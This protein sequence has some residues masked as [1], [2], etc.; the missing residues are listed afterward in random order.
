MKIS[1]GKLKFQKLATLVRN[2]H[3]NAAVPGPLV[4][5]RTLHKIGT[6]SQARLS[7]KFYHYSG[8]ILSTSWVFFGA[9]SQNTQNYHQLGS[10]TATLPNLDL[11]AAT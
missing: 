11:V 4:R 2:S 10:A 3:R 6:F 1:P 8:P 9:N 5:F 7:I